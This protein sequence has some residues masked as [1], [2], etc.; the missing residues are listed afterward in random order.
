LEAPSTTSHAL[1]RESRV[2]KE[3]AGA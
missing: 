1:D 2:V 3:V